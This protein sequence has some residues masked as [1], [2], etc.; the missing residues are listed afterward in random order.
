MSLV[1]W[2]Q[3]VLAEKTSYEVFPGEAAADTVCRKVRFRVFKTPC[4]PRVAVSDAR[5]SDASHSR[6]SFSTSPGS[7]MSTIPRVM[8]AFD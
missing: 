2:C 8:M 4:L 7:G 5:C 6:L 3:I 1:R